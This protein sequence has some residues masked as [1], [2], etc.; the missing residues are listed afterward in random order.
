ME[1]DELGSDSPQVQESGIKDHALNLVGKVVESVLDMMNE[2]LNRLKIN[3]QES[4]AS[5]K[6]L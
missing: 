4:Q 1:K 2:Q 5:E 6:K 3:L